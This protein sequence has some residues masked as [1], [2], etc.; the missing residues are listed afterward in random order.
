MLASSLASFLMVDG[1]TWSILPWSG[2]SRRGEG[3][4]GQHAG[5]S[6]SRLHPVLKSPSEDVALGRTTT[7]LPSIQNGDLAP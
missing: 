1:N 6:R 4:K 3:R 2:T 7:R 5:L